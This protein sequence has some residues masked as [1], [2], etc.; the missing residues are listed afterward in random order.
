MVSSALEQLTSPQAREE[1]YGRQQA[2]VQTVGLLGLHGADHSENPALI[3]GGAAD[4]LQ[5]IDSYIPSDSPFDIDAIVPRNMFQ[6]LAQ[7]PG[8]TGGIRR[9]DY[10]STGGIINP[11][12]TIPLPL[13]II[14]GSEGAE[15]SPFI[16]NTPYYGRP[17]EDALET[18]LGV[19][20][21]PA[22]VIAAT[23]VAHRLPRVKD[24]AG[25]IK[26]QVV[27]NH[28]RHPIVDDALWRLAV[29]IA[30]KRVITW[31][32][33]TPP[34]RKYTLRGPKYPTWLTVLMKRDFEHPAFAAI[35]RL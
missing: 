1:F 14:G 21:V 3:F 7:N 6:R 15:F 28:T 30:M 27:G 33:E 32:V 19:L 23:K 4:V 2:V 31:D 16:G 18:S 10:T 5:G 20:V 9:I 26:A 17:T 29:A 11:S 34:A 8:F 35:P 24:L 13:T 22:N 25:I 12:A